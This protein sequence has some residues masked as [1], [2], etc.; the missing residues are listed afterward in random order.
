[1]AFGVAL[2]VLRDGTRTVAGFA[3][4]DR[5]FTDAEIERLGAV[6]D[7]LH[8]ETTGSK[9]LSDGDREALKNMSIRLTHA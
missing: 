3:R 8:D 4:G 2:A 9:G 5:E 7:Q 6:L 1:M